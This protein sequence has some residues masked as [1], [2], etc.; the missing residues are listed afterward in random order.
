MDNHVIYQA[1]TM[2]ALLS[3][4]YDG[5]VTFGELQKHGD[6]GI[7]TFHELDGEMIAFDDQFF[8]LYPDGT[9]KKVS[10]D[11]TTPFSTVTFF[12]KQ[13][14]SRLNKAVTRPEL[15][16]VLDGLVESP[17]LFHAIRIDGHF[18]EVNTRT[19]PHQAKP[20]PPFVE[21]TKSQPS[22]HFADVDGVIAGFWT[23]AFAQGIGVA[24]YHLHFINEARNG[25]G[26][27][28][29]FVLEGGDISICSGRDFQLALPH[30]DMYLK[31]DLSVANLE[32]D[33]MIAEGSY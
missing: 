22:F 21:V 4:L 12:E 13:Q 26:H 24:G 18:R 31:Q 30:D 25:G 14:T 3:G 7:G 16:K 19:V 28:L 11:E 1:S 27:V 9:A 6:F 15:E 32:G 29:D 17:N 8:H 2:I 33:I 5:T 23:P 10:L 20:Y